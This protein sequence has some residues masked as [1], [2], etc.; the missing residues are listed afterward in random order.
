M[1]CSASVNAAGWGV[2]TGQWGGKPVDGLIGSSTDGGGYAFFGN[3]AVSDAHG[4]ADL[5]Q[6]QF[7]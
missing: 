2:V 5:I 6:R 4:Q 1:A 7:I 3:T